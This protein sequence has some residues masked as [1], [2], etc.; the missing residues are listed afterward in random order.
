MHNDPFTIDPTAFAEEPVVAWSKLASLSPRFL[1]ESADDGRK[2]LARYSFLGL[3]KMQHIRLFAG[4]LEIDGVSRSIELTRAH[5]LTTMRDLLSQA[6]SP[7]FAASGLRLPGGLVGCTHFDAVRIFEPRLSAKLSEDTLI[8]EWLAPRTLLV[9]DNLRR[10]AAVLHDGDEAE[11]AEMTREVTAALS[12]PAPRQPRPG[13]H[14]S[15]SPSMSDAAFLDA[16]TRAQAHIVAGDIFQVVLSLCHTGQTDLD[17]FSV[18][19]ALRRLNPSPYLYF[20][21]LG[22][23]QIV[24]SSPEAL[25][26][27]EGRKAWLRPIAG[28]RPRGGNE[29]EDVAH[30]VD[31]LADP[32]EAAEHV[33]LVDL[34]RNDLGRVAAPGSVTVAPFRTIER[35]SHVMHIVSGVSGEL[36]AEHDAMDL[37]AACFPAGT[38]SGAPKVRALQIIDDLEPTPRGLYS[39]TVGYFG[40]GGD[41]D[42]AIAIR[43][44][45]FQD[46]TYRCQAGAGIVHRS[47]AVSELAECK[48][49]AAALMRALVLAEER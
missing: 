19:R 48:A 38:V 43:T 29:A 41:M 47:V 35:Y 31:L 27:L 16:V 10:R 25:V 3:G 12:K 46:G 24:G 39:G 13:R 42:Q 28:T 5:L 36:A 44:L 9:F 34:A 11:Q 17:P 32:K 49:K 14:G 4:R 18:Y 1:L 2:Q 40:R 15:S 33:M 6:P 22:D 30:E 23:R 7:G 37:F 8:G 21:D 26:R 20:L 45:E